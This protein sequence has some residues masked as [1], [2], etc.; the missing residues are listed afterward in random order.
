MSNAESRSVEDF[1]ASSVSHTRDN[2]SAELFR[3]NP[4][5]DDPMFLGGDAEV[6]VRGRFVEVGLF[7]RTCKIEGWS[8]IKGRSDDEA[9]GKS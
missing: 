4:A 5:W 1:R 6:V 7:S 9:I 2:D 8:V 3:C